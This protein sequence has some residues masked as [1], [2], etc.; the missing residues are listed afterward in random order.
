MKNTDVTIHKIFK[1][2]NGE[3]VVGS[4]IKETVSYIEIEN[5][6]RFVMY[7]T[8]SGNLN[9]S[10]LKWDPTFDMKYPVRIFK[11]SIVACAEPTANIMKNYNEI[12]HAGEHLSDNEIVESV[13]E[14]L[15]ESNTENI[16]DTLLKK[17]KSDIIH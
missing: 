1:L 7:M 13:G 2:S 9:I 15:E 5:P 12:V 16:M 3:T 14:D 6:L 4:V 10:I 11:T 17:Y 8:N